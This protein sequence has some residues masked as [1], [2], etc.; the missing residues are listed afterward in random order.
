VIALTEVRRVVKAALSFPKIG[1]LR[2]PKA[3][4]TG[5]LGGNTIPIRRVGDDTKGQFFS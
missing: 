2:F 5:F 3:T 1:S 4:E